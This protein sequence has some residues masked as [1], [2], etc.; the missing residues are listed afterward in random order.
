MP[1]KILLND[2]D[3]IWSLAGC[4]PVHRHL[5]HPSTKAVV[6]KEAFHLRILRIVFC[7]TLSGPRR[8]PFVGDDK[9]HA[10]SQLPS[11]RE[12]QQ[13]S[14]NVYSKEETELCW[15]SF[16]TCAPYNSANDGMAA[17]SRKFER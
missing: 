9:V 2:I 13:L 11:T 10:C 15:I 14:E 6:I 1:A 16:E 3:E 7:R 4:C 12:N 5:S 8:S 17:K